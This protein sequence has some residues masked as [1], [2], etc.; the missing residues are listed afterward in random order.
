MGKKLDLTG[1]KF[2]KLTAIKPVGLCENKRQVMW[3]FLCEC[4]NTIQSKGSPVKSGYKKSCGCSVKDINVKH[5]FSKTCLYNILNSIK[6]RCN[7]KNSKA[8]PHYGGRGIKICD[9]WLES[10]ENFYEDMGDRPS[11]NHSIERLDVNGD[12]HPDNCVWA[13][14]EVQ[15]RNHR[16]QSNNTT[17]VTGVVKE[18]ETRYKARWEDLEG[19]SKSRSFSIQKYGERGAFLLACE[20]REN[21]LKDLNRQGAGY[22]EN[23]GK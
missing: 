7:N 11:P 8:Y 1:Q 18:M 5:G 14:S 2:N 22:S 17:G 9:R 15:A 19:A 23:H 12:Y 10:F 16:K 13:T 3:E 4:G 20:A 6:T 21:A